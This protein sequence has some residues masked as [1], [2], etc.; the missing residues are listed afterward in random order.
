MLSD[1]LCS[2]WVGVWQVASVHGGGSPM[3]ETVAILG[4]YPIQARKEIAIYLAG[5][6]SKDEF[7]NKVEVKVVNE[8]LESIK[9]FGEKSK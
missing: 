6:K 3:M 1:M 7:E 2:G 5:I 8:F 9:V 4:N